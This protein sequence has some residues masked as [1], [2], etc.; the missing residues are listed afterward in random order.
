MFPALEFDLDDVEPV[1][2]PHLLSGQRE[3]V[4][5]AISRTPKFVADSAQ[6][7]LRLA[8]G[9]KEERKFISFLDAVNVVM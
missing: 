8:S 6:T 5:P 9:L 1:D 2:E 7:L 4:A 3:H